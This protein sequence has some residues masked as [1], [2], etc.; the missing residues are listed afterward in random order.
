MPSSLLILC[1]LAAT[2]ALAASPFA[3][4]KGT[5]ILHL[6]LRTALMAPAGPNPEGEVSLK[7]RQQ[8]HAD[9]QKFTLEASGLVGGA[10][11]D[12]FLLL[13][14][15]T[16]P[17]QVP[18]LA[19][20]ANPDGQASVKLMHLGHTNNS[21]KT[22]PA[23]ELDPLSDLLAI[24]IHDAGDNLV[25]SADLTDPD[26]LQYLVKRRLDNPGVDPDAE[27]GLFLKQ[28][29]S[30]ESFRLRAVN[31]TGMADYRLA[32]NCPNGVPAP[33]CEFGPFTTD[34]KGRLDITNAPG[35]P[36]PF[37]MTQVLL[38][39]GGDQVVLSTE[40]P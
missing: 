26:W 24:E 17:I 27:G 9:V 28:H 5:D 13:R 34:A 1:F 14:G 4:G 12:V 25:L 2:P 7:L 29:G 15:A 38:I 11:Y 8:G 21:G 3:G 30:Q 31:L 35:T 20:E 39:D 36:P 33:A 37:D 32:I 18:Q 6:T 23:A 19:F 16:D 40:L 22:F 10:P